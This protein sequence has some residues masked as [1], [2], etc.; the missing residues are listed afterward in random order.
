[1]SGMIKAKA[2]LKWSAIS[3]INT[4]AMAP[5]TMHIMSS[6][7]ANLVCRPTPRYAR[8]KMVGNIMLSHK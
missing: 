6:D 5:P 1:M 4:G 8:A 3:P 2:M 7:E